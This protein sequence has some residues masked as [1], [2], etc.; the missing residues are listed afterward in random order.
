M[1]IR[2]E[3]FALVF[4]HWSSGGALTSEFSLTWR[5]TTEP[6]MAIARGGAFSFRK[7]L[8]SAGNSCP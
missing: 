1:P 2:F 5:S 6:E 8:G 3:E 4:G 7:S